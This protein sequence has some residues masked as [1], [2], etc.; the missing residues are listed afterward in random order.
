MCTVQQLRWKVIGSVRGARKVKGVRSRLY[1]IASNNLGFYPPDNKSAFQYTENDDTL[2]MI[3]IFEQKE[4]ALMFENEL[5]NERV[6]LLAATNSLEIR[7]QVSIADSGQ[8]SSLAD[9]KR[10]FY[11]DYQPSESDSPQDTISH[12]TDQYTIY[13][14]KSDLFTY[15][16]IEDI[17]LFGNHCKAQGCHLMSEKTLLKV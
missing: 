12:L 16:S 4:K 6:T 13:D 14:P 11:T 3:V 9:L 1:Q 7:T 15:Q 5:N 2:N 10:I 17:N 8:F